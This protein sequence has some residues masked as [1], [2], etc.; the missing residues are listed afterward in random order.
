VNELAQKKQKTS[1]FADFLLGRK[2]ANK[3]SVP[4]AVKCIGDI[5]SGDGSGGGGEDCDDYVG[6]GDNNQHGNNSGGDGG[7]GNHGGGDGDGEDGV[8]TAMDPLSGVI[9]S[10]I[11][12]ETILCTD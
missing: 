1:E 12:L 11:P 2:C 10:S 5:R 6:D 3:E 8:P 7:D 9:L 4:A